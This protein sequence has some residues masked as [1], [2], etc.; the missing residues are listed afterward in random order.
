MFESAE[1]LSSGKF[2]SRGDWLHPDRVIDSYEVIFVIGGEVFI[3]ENGTEFALKS[4]D[5]LLLEPQVRHFGYKSSKNTSFYW[6]HWSSSRNLLSGLKS[7][8]IE[9]PYN[10][11]LLFSQLLHYSADSVLPECL[12]YITRL[13]LAEV[14]ENDVKTTDSKLVNNIADWI[15]ANSDILLKTSDIADHF[16]YNNDYLSRLFKKYYGKS[17]KKYIDEAKLNYIKN[18]LLNTNA[19]LNE[20]AVACGF[21][22]YKYF[23]KFFK[24]HEKMTPTEFC[25]TY[26]KTHINNR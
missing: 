12:D 21:E 17:L 3:N 10:L 14:Y 11:S 23:L 18:Q 26:S 2:V 6:M 1:Y 4:N 22:E 8:H 9:S 25:A 7:C 24:Y 15:R 16:G 19:T 20:V 13:I 5:L